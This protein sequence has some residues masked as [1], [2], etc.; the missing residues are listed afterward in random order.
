MT[1][2]FGLFT[3][4]VADDKG[5]YYRQLRAPGDTYSRLPMVWGLDERGRVRFFAR[6]KAEDETWVPEI[7]RR[8]NLKPGSAD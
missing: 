6:P 4:L 5:D 7:T 2:S 1:A 8:L 3:Q